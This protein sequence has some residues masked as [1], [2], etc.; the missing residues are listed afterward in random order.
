MRGESGDVRGEDDGRGLTDR[1]DNGGGGQTQGGDDADGFDKMYSTVHM[2]GDEKARLIIM[3]R[4]PMKSVIL[5][6]VIDQKQTRSSAHGE[7]TIQ[8][9]IWTLRSGTRGR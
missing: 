4:C 9:R 8:S 6:R 5:P 3:Q 7:N 2:T 1:Q